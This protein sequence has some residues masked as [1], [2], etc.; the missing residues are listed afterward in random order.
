MGGDASGANVM[1][2][3]TRERE[4]GGEGRCDGRRKERTEKQERV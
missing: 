4:R 1:E 3:E 2:W